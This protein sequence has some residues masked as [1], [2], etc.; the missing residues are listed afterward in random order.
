MVSRKVFMEFLSII[1]LFRKLYAANKAITLNAIFS[2]FWPQEDG[3][4]HCGMANIL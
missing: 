4:E 2:A 3:R 1:K